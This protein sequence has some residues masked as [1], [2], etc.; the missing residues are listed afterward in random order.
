MV[1][2]INLLFTHSEDL[3]SKIL[4]GFDVTTAAQIHF[5]VGDVP[6]HKHPHRPLHV[7]LLLEWEV[8]GPLLEAPEGPKMIRTR[9]QNKPQYKGIPGHDPKPLPK[10]AKVIFVR[11]G[12]PLSRIDFTQVLHDVTAQYTNIEIGL[13]NYYNNINM[14]LT[15]TVHVHLDTE[16]NEVGPIDVAFHNSSIKIWKAMEHASEEMFRDC[17]KMVVH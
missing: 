5:R 17:L 1:T 16:D 13:L 2:M 9:V 10:N 12:I 7:L 11:W 6:C 4:Q 14:M 8:N 3:L 15:E